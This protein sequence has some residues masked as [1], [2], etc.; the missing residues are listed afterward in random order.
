TLLAYIQL[1]APALEGDTLEETAS[2]TV[3]G[4]LLTADT[5]RLE[6]LLGLGIGTDLIERQENRA[7]TK[8]AEVR[9]WLSEKRTEQVKALAEAWRSST[10]FVDLW[11]VPGLYVEPAGW[12]YDPLVARTAILDFINT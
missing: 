8:R 11:H 9:R 1:Y 10:S 6:F 2:E 12:D 5:G 3:E 4:F 7:Y